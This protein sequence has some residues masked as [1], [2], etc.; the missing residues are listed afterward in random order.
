MVNSDHIFLTI[1]EIIESIRMDFQQYPAQTKLFRKLAPMVLHDN[2]LVLGSGPQRGYWHQKSRKAT[3]RRIGDD[4]L[5]DLIRK[6]LASTPIP[7]EKWPDICRLI[8]RAT[9]WPGYHPSTGRPGVWLDTEMRKFS[10]RQCGRCCRALHY[11]DECRQE[12]VEKWQACG[13]EDILKWVLAVD[14]GTPPHRYRIWVY[15]GTQRLA[16]VCPWFMHEP[17]QTHALCLIH[18]VK[19]FICRQYPGSQKHAI[20]TGCN[21][22]GWDSA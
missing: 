16:P 9:A 5:G 13:R 20:M 12:D 4:A 8:F 15:P 21:G 2:I 6:R 3:P 11:H 22:S 17:D 14:G 19:P 1:P 10:C 7:L 18:E